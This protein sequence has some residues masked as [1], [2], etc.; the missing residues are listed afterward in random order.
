VVGLEAEPRRARDAIGEELL[1]AGRGPPDLDVGPHA[2]G[3][4]L[5][6]G[7]LLVAT[8]GHEA[9]A[10]WLDE[11]QRRRAGEPGE[12]ADVREVRDEERVALRR[13]QA[14]PQAI[15]P[16]RDV[17]RRERHASSLATAA[18]ARG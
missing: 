17:H 16:A 18:T 12:V 15:D 7:L 6:G 11:Q 8:V 1:L 9:Q 3:A 14:A 2:G 4:E 13:G 10:R 5:A